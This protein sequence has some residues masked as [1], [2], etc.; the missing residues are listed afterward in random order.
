MDRSP[1]YETEDAS[2]TLAGEAMKEIKDSDLREWFVFHC[3]QKSFEDALWEQGADVAEQDPHFAELRLKYY[4]AKKKICDYLYMIED[5]H[6][7]DLDN[8]F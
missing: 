6:P 8:K 5:T 4:K 2:S 7:E 3:G 1:V